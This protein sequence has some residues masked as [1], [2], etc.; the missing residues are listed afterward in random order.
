MR[1]GRCCP[2]APQQPAR[3]AV[4]QCRRKPLCALLS[5]QCGHPVAQVGR[6]PGR[7]SHSASALRTRDL[8]SGCTPLRASGRNLAQV[9]GC[10]RQ[11]TSSSPAEPS[12][13]DCSEHNAREQV[14][15]QTSLLL[16]KMHPRNS[17]EFPGHRQSWQSGHRWL[18]SHLSHQRDWGLLQRRRQRVCQTGG[19]FQRQPP[20]QPRTAS[21]TGTTPRSAPPCCS[22]QGERVLQ[23][24]H[25]PL[26]PDLQEAGFSGRGE[27]RTR[28]THREGDGHSQA[29]PRTQQAAPGARPV[30]AA[31][32]SWS[33]LM[34]GPGVLMRRG[35]AVVHTAQPEEPVAPG[36]LEPG[37]PVGADTLATF[38][39]EP[40]AGAQLTLPC[41]QTC[42]PSLCGATQA[43]HGVRGVAEPG[44]QDVTPAK[45]QGEETASSLPTH[46]CSTLL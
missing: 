3:P 41:A 15:P 31:P 33:G 7:G 36:T 20:C 10:S 9:P 24:R 23:E 30:T 6:Y 39:R 35:A 46:P 38:R 43:G 32:V 2:G 18:L 26:F 5:A 25:R 8:A 19:K 12:S 34:E 16:A 27:A 44:Q 28:D 13:G 14:R 1:K 29:V 37:P 45:R 11:S 22:P 42:A 17:G 21:A 4:S 40:A